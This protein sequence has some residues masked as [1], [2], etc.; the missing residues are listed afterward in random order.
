MEAT[1]EIVNLGFDGYDLLNGK[2]LIEWADP[3]RS[4]TT[5]RHLGLFQ[6]I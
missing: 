4:R 5:T 1:S 2:N 3:P 6:S